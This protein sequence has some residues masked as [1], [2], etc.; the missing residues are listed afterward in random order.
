M[1]WLLLDMLCGG[2]LVGLIYIYINF[3]KRKSKFSNTVVVIA[4]LIF[5]GIGIF[6]LVQAFISLVHFFTD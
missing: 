6:A 3:V 5:S 4:V 2:L 1:K